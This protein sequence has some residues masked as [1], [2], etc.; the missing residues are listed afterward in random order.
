MSTSEGNFYVFDSRGSGEIS[1]RDKVHSDVIMD[2]VL[3]KNEDYAVTC[4][5]DRNINLVKFIKI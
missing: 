4:S 5:F 1:Q 2:F 3:T